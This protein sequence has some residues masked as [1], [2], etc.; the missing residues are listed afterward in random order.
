MADDLNTALGNW[1]STVARG[2]KISN[3][4][5]RGAALTVGLLMPG[6][7]LSV[8]ANLRAG[9]LVLEISFMP[10]NVS[11]F[12]VKQFRHCGSACRYLLRSTND[13]A[14]RQAARNRHGHRRQAPGGKAR[15]FARAYRRAPPSRRSALQHRRC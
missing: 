13:L 9:A 12:I 11:S 4:P 15:A 1:V 7:E 2:G 3:D 14:L 10:V 6:A 8:T 5:D